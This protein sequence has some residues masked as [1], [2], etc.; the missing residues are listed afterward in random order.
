MTHQKKSDRKLL[1]AKTSVFLLVLLLGWKTQLQGQ[2]LEKSPKKTLPV[3]TLSVQTL[4]V[5]TLSVQTLSVQDLYQQGYRLQQQHQTKAAIKLYLQALKKNPLHP[6][7]HYEIGWSYWVL[8]NWKSA[9]QHW[10]IALKLKAPHPG[11][12]DYIKRALEN[13]NSEKLKRPSINTKVSKNGVSL[14]LTARLQHHTPQPENPLDHFDP[15]L[16]SPKSVQIHP[17]KKK[18]YVQ[19]LEAQATLVYNSHTLAK[20]KVI[21]HH[22]GKKDAS[23]FDN[24][25]N[26]QL[27][28]RL[29]KDAP[30]NLNHFSAKPVEGVFSHQGRY[31]WVSLYRRDY[32]IQAALPSAVSIIDTRTDSIVRVMA[33]AAI[34]KA[35]AVSPDG[36]Q[37]AI[38]HWGENTVGLVDISHSNPQQFKYTAMIAVEKPFR[39]STQGKKLNRDRHC[40]LCLRGTVYS[41]DGRY[42]LVSQ[43]K[44]GGIAILDLKTKRLV[45]Q[46]IGMP[47]APRHLVLSPDGQ[48][49]FIAASRSG[50]ISKYR[51][52]S[53]LENTAQKQQKLKPWA[54]LYLG[55]GIRTL[56]I[57]TD[58]RWLLAAV[59][60]E[61]RLAVIS[62]TRLEHLL[63]IDADPYPVGLAISPDNS[64][65][66]A[67]AQG[68]N[69]K[70]GNSVMRYQLTIPDSP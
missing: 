35:L 5:Q 31:L 52:S 12:P 50:T 34:P 42:L 32:D 48:W 21:K 7:T 16:F 40:G 13:D 57:T 22:F 63:N 14:Q 58:G 55:L 28:Q 1:L 68:R 65:I 38:V 17:S 4:S 27:W 43:M 56:C 49:L 36:L 37:L 47:H 59:N 66:W 60:Q 53:L 6:L 30:P 33:T 29:Q 18:I 8:E 64:Q 20:L 41:P 15:H 9:A 39:V 46:V 51:L 2:Q 62:A 25:E 45:S 11:L 10:K 23:L 19:A 24:S 67:T 3:Q 54:N 70:G 26:T 69:L 61:K 44:T